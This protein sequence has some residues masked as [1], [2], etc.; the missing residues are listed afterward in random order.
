MKSFKRLVYPYLI[1]AAIL[2]VLPMLIIVFY[3]FTTQGNEVIP[4]KF[5]L[6]SFVRFF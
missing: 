5:T 1:W 3:A 2:I 4:V 6:E